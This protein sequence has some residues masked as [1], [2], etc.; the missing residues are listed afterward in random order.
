MLYR[1]VANKVD[2]R[3]FN[4]MIF[5][6]LIPSFLLFLYEKMDIIESIV[7]IISYIYKSNYNAVTLNLYSEVCQLPSIKLEKW[8]I[9]WLLVY[10]Q[11]CKLITILD[12]F[13][14]ENAHSP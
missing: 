2:L 10:L 13:S 11:I 12:F 3:V 14:S 7:V 1:K 5:F 9:Q 8:K 4:T 6:L